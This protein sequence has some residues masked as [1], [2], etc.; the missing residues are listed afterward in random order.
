MRWN[1]LLPIGS[2]LS[3]LVLLTASAYA[4][5]VT[6]DKPADPQLARAEVAG[7]DG[8][9][10]AEVWAEKDAVVADRSLAAAVRYVEGA[11]ASDTARGLKA[12]RSLGE[13]VVNKATAGTEHAWATATDVV[14]RTMEKLG[15]LVGVA[16]RPVGG[17]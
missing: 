7:P 6:T 17:A 5:A 12:A 8:A 14:R 9:R 11:L 3:V 1:H 4:Q 2:A 16:G 13:K 15:H 10:S